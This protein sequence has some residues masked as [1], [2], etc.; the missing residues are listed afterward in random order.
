[1]IRKVKHA[2]FY[3]QGRIRQEGAW[4]VAECMGLPVV[5]QGETD[6]QALAN[7]IEATQLFIETCLERGTLER[8]L[9]KYRWRPR[10]TPHRETPPR[11]FTFPV[12]LPLIVKRA[13]DECRT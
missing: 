2:T 12:P 11:G 4:Y 13:L 8:V 6:S 3:L 5:T 7:L 10:L 1:V 9:L